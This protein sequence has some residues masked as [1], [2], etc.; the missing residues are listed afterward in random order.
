MNGFLSDAM[1]SPVSITNC[2][3][4]TPQEF[5]SGMKMMGVDSL[6]GIKKT[7]TSLDPGFME[8]AEFREF[9]RFAFQFSRE[10]SQ[11]C[12]IGGPSP[13]LYVRCCSKKNAVV[14]LK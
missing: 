12:C 13:C 2:N 1:M 3:I 10:V 7:L 9:Y 4:I 5:E 6:E 14:A 11:V 8:H